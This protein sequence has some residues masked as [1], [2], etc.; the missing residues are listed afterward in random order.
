MK[1]LKSMKICKK[2]LKFQGKLWKSFANTGP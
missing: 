2:I 1:K